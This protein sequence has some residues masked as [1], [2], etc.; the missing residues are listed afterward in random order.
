M[1]RTMKFG[2]LPMYVFAPMNTAPALMAAS[3]RGVTPD[4]LGGRP[5]DCAMATKVR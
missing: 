2:P 4:H 1:A 3:T 5:S